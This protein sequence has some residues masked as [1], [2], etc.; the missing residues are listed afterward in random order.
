LWRSR[1]ASLTLHSLAYCELYLTLA[2]IFAPGRF[3]FELFETDITNV[4]IAH[5]FFNAC[6]RTD[7]KGIRMLVK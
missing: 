3:G 6:Y 1:I 4:E 5:D 7:S 2:A